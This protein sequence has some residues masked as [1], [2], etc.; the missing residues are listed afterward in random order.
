ALLICLASRLLDVSVESASV[1]DKSPAAAA[2]ELLEKLGLDSSVG[3]DPNPFANRTLFAFLPGNAA[4]YRA[5]SLHD[6]LRERL[7]ARIPIV[8]GVSS[9][10][11]GKKFGLGTQFAQRMSGRDL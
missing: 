7:R 2:R 3:E 6:V 5:T 1:K 4:T 10:Y 8:G 9:A 11:D